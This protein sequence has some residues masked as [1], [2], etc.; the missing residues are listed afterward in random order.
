M[1]I[2]KDMPT[3]QSQLHLKRGVTVVILNCVERKIT[4]TSKILNLI[5]VP[6]NNGLNIWR[7]RML[8]LKKC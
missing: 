2:T 5:V 3:S 7:Y 1:L 4:N 8:F 6:L